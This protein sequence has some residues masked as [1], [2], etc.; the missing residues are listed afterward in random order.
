[1]PGRHITSYLL[2]LLLR[3]GYSLNRTADFETVRQ[4]K[5][6][7]CFVAQDFACESK[8]RPL[9]CKRSIVAAVRGSPPLPFMPIW[10]RKSLWHPSTRA[11]P[12]QSAFEQIARTSCFA[13]RLLMLEGECTEPGGVWLQIARETTY[14]V[15][16]YTLPDGCTVRV[17]SE[18]FT[19]PEALFTPDLIDKEG[20]GISDMIFNCIQ[21]RSCPP[22]RQTLKCSVLQYACLLVNQNPFVVLLT[23]PAFCILRKRQVEDKNVRAESCMK[24]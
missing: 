10:F 13:C 3:R 21:V 7:A 18:R 19:A 4:L 1:M 22:M 20:D 2:Q 14:L 8:A 15:Q 9:S 6:Q 5:E 16:K 12:S 24:E 11:P 17:A 23:F